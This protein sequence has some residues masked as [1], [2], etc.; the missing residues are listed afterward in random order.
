MIYKTMI[1]LL[2]LLIFQDSWYSGKI[3]SVTDG[4]TFVMQMKE[5]NI[6][7]RLEGIDAPE[8]KQPFSHESKAFLEKYLHKECRLQKTGVD[9][10]G[11]TLGV[12]WVNGVNINLL[13]VKEGYAWHF[14]KY[15]KDGFLAEAEA[16]ARKN[17]KGLWKEQN[18][19]APWDW[20]K[21]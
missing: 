8:N 19:I 4:D 21:K 16:D 7:V 17:R 6:R 1:P 14:K 12:L 11:R 20:R 13:M 18:P 3:L 10:F 5:G 15:S 9:R 2:L